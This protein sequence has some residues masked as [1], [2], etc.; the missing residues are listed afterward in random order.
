MTNPIDEML[1]IATSATKEEKLDAAGI[2]L[3]YVTEQ[4]EKLK[5]EKEALEDTIHVLTPDEPGEFVVE[6]KQYSFAVIRSEIF[7]WD[8]EEIQK[9]VPTVT[10]PDI[11][12]VKYTLDKKKYLS[13]PPSEQKEWYSTL[14]RKPGSPRVKVS[15]KF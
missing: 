5:L 3:L 10:L 9:L 15:K 12:K 11:V 8:S 14:E 2:R 4:I 13:L 6:G 7:S 1:G